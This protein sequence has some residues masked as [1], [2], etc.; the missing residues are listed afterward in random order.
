MRQGGREEG[1]R[2]TVF[3]PAMFGSEKGG[4][5]VTQPLRLED[6]EVAKEGIVIKVHDLACTMQ[7]ADHQKKGREKGRERRGRGGTECN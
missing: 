5:D 1:G 6:Q 7:D 4:H 2:G 3:D